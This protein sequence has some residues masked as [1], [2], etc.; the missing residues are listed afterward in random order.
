MK[1]GCCCCGRQII[2]D[3]GSDHYVAPGPATLMGLGKFCCSECSD[4]LG[5][6]GLF[7]EERDDLL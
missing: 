2:K 6:D 7:P 5:E 1:I 4:D 3:G